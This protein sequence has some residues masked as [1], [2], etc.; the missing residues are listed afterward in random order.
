MKIDDTETGIEF[1]VKVLPGASKTRFAGEYGDMVKIRISAAPE[2]GK[3]NKELTA[4]LAKHLG[5]K[6]NDIE[7][8]SGTTS[9]VKNIHITCNN[10]KITKEKLINLVQV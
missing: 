5:L 3:A 2:K 4:F 9:Q 1:H 10:Q 7:I 6:K 8:L